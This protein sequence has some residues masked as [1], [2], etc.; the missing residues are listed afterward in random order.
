MRL[1]DRWIPVLAATVGVLGGMGGA[2]I[3][4]YI[5]KETQQQQ[6]EN[7][8]E[9]ASDDLRRDAYENYLQAGYGYFVDLQLKAGGIP[10][11]EDELK[12]HVDAVSGAE[13]AVALYGSTELEEVMTN[14][15][16]AL[17]F[18]RLSSAAVFLNQF[19]DLAKEE[20][21]SLIDE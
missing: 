19:R 6:F 13:A 2:L 21:A 5:S 10:L 16:E 9:A 8:Q 3:G 11:G 14:L 15:E 17:G 20:I 18:E 12:A 4:G 7:Q 1:Q